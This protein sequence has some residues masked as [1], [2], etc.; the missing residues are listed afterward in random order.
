MN[1]LDLVSDKLLWEK[2][3][4]G[5]CDA[6]DFARR[7]NHSLPYAGKRHWH[8]VEALTGRRYQKLVATAGRTTPSLAPMGRTPIS[9]A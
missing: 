6:C 1:V 8:I 4:E 3:Y 9:R 2:S 5:G 7:E